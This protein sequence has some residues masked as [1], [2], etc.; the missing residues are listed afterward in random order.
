MFIRCANREYT[1]LV[2]V[3]LRDRARIA[4]KMV[5][6]IGKMWSRYVC[7]MCVWCSAIVSLFVSSLSV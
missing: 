1:K 6:W 4:L 2:G 7:G 5:L 3:G